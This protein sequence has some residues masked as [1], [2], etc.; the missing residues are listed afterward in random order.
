MHLR[1]IEDKVLWH[2]LRSFSYQTLSNDVEALSVQLRQRFPLDA[3]IEHGEDVMRLGADVETSQ[4]CMDHDLPFAWSHL[5]PLL[6]PLQ[7][8]TSCFG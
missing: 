2:G 8:D 3:A 5:D 7:M 6:V 1:T 4:P